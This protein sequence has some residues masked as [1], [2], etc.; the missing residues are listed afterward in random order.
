METDK[1][2]GSRRNPED[3]VFFAPI[4]YIQNI[5]KVIDRLETTR[6]ELKKV[7]DGMKT[8]QE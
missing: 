5:E 6:R 2:D 1:S 3:E 4:E 8:I 7:A